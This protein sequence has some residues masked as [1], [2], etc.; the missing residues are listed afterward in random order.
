MFLLPKISSAQRGGIDI[1]ELQSL[2][3]MPV[4]LYD[5]LDN[6]I[7]YGTSILLLNYN[8]KETIY[9]LTARHVFEKAIKIDLLM[10]DGG[11]G[12]EKL[13]KNPI[14]LYDSSGNAL[15][16]TFT[17]KSGTNVDLAIIPIFAKDKAPDAPDPKILTRSS[18]LFSDS[19]FVGDRLLVFGFADVKQFDFIRSGDPLATSGVVAFETGH[20]YVLD[21][22]VHQGMSGGIVFKEFPYQGRFLYLAVGVV[23][24]HLSKYPGYSVVTKLDFID[25]I[26]VNINGKS[27]GESK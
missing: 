3:I 24:G 25:S 21:K 7:G 14:S 12:F 20:S 16:H 11:K 4:R 18:C 19:V 9:L 22:E 5:S 15:F 23:A 1:A 13:L 2:T 8:T 26:M 27:W 10:G 6:S 17:S